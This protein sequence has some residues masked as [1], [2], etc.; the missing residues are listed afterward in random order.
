MAE[1][2]RFF[3]LFF[4]VTLKNTLCERGKREIFAKSNL[5]TENQAIFVRR[6]GIIAFFAVGTFFSVLLVSSLSLAAADV[7]YES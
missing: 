4:S 3:S 6:K 2:S 5:S 7:N 1:N